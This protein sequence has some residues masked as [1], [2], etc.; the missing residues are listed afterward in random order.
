M[1]QLER[2]ALE[3]ELFDV[4]VCG[5]GLAGLTLGL[6]LRREHPSLRVL[7]VEKT[8]RPLPPGCHK[9]G[10]S[11]VEL[12]SSYF[13][14]LGLK[15]YLKEKQLFKHGLRFFP[16]G[17]HLPIEKRL[18]I[19]P[20]Q[21]PIV[22]SYQLDR[23]TFESDLRGFLE[24]AGATLVEGASVREI[25]LKTGGEPHVV[26]YARKVGETTQSCTVKAKWVADASG[27]NALL[28]RRLKLTRGSR[29]TAC[30]G[31]FRVQG[32]VDITSWVPKDVST[33]HETEAAKHRWR[34]TNHFMGPGYW[35]WVIPLSSGMT[36]IG[37]VI[38]SELHSFDDVRSLE[39]CME[40][41]KKHEPVFYRELQGYEVK[42]FLCLN[43][44]SHCIGR[45][46]SSERWALVG[47]AGAFVDPL[48]SPGSD[49][50]AYANSF[51]TELIRVDLMGGDLEGRTRDLNL[52]YRALVSGNI[53]V[54]AQAAPVY[55]HPRAM[56]AKVYWDNF[57]YWSYSCQYFMRK[58][59]CLS[60]AEAAPF[61]EVGQRFIELS[62]YMQSLF[63]A[64][65][66][67]APEEPEPGFMAMP[68]FPSVLVDAH[69]AL[70][71]EMTPSETLAYM[72]K[73][74]QEAEVIAGEL[75]VSTL[76]H[77][78]DEKA[79]A[80]AAQVKLGTWRLSVDSARV[81]MEQEVGMA[82]RHALSPLARDVERGT[83]RSQRKTSAGGLR[84]L[85]SPLLA[86]EVKS[87]MPLAPQPLAVAA[88]DVA[89]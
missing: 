2:D 15:E 83:G 71:D 42:D 64:W 77:V 82:R 38:H 58:I 69:I 78:G 23:G 4:V 30:A 55:G 67:L 70:R 31:W 68:R 9:V 85:L 28:R 47:E 26:K 5:G 18:E 33:W 79:A 41:L 1:D 89:E 13:E 36:S 32:K 72:Q 84:G 54:Y 62:N 56:L 29:H 16:G 52:Q 39:R 80:I 50:I 59:Y 43:D 46:W 45:G 53:D 20:M 3:G 57:A 24:E 73:R 75:V 48:Y 7:V 44:Y 22:P 76:S 49:F 17:G 65:A 34:S 19:G 11:S 27:R 12:G 66:Q 25:E 88:A 74:L 37:V 6:Q 14:S 51:T 63:R 21:E 81:E 61:I 8:A 40:F 60:G 86:A 10:E 87:P 35:A